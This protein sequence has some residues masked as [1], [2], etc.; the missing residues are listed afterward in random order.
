MPEPD[1]ARA[2]V[3]SGAISL[4]VIRPTSLRRFWGAEV[5]LATTWCAASSADCAW[6]EFRRV[7]SVASS[8]AAR[9][10]LSR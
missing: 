3:V 2:E 7:E 6:R 10:A 1:A 4:D 8:G 9:E 5:K